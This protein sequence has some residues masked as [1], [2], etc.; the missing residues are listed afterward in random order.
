M[1]NSSVNGLDSLKGT[2]DWSTF[3]NVWNPSCVIV[4]TSFNETCYKKVLVL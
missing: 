3:C 2:L 1:M 4:E